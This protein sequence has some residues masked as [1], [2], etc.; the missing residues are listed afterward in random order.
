LHRHKAI[1][2]PEGGATYA[3][4]L[5]GTVSEIHPVGPLKPTAMDSNPSDTAASTETESRSMSKDMYGPLCIKPDD[6][7]PNAEVVNTCLPEGACLKRSP[8]LI[9][10]FSDV[11]SG[12]GSLTLAVWHPNLMARS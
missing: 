3:S 1:G 4:V 9:T 12:S 7:T 2:P 11:R 10:C 5:V 8:I 6:T